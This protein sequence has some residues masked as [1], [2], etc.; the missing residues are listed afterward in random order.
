M[1]TENLSH[2]RTQLRRARLRNVARK[3]LASFAAGRARGEATAGYVV[4]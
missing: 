4:W 3:P 2:T 1:V